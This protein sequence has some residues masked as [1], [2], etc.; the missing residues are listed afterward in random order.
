[1]S[2]GKWNRLK[3][4]LKFWERIQRK[5]RIVRKFDKYW[6]IGLF[7][8]AYDQWLRLCMLYFCIIQPDEYLIII[9]QYLN[10]ITLWTSPK[11]KEI[12]EFR[13]TYSPLIS[14]VNKTLTSYLFQNRILYYITD[15]R[16]L[17]VTTNS[18]SL[19]SA[20][21]SSYLSSLLSRLGWVK[22]VQLTLPSAISPAY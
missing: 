4:Y 7:M 13:I 11:R 6:L 9:I 17:M 20:C 3:G 8:T 5:V 21:G 12:T 1:M 16:E 22:Q 15:W 18:L 2:W 14:A 10:Y 19:L